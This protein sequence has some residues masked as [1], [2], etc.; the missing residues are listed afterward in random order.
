[1]TKTFCQRVVE[2]CEKHSDKTAMRIVGD[3]TEIYSYGEMLKQIRSVAY[4]ISQESVEFGDRVALIGENHPCW[5]IAYLG[6]LYRGAVCVPV[7]PHGEIETITNFLENSEA[8]LA[9]LSP[10][11]IEKFGQIQEKLGRHIP[12][13]VWRM[14][15]DAGTRTNGDEK[16]ISEKITLSSKSSEKQKTKN[17]KQYLNGFQRFEEWA[18][19][20][21]P[22]SFAKAE[23]PAKDEDTALLIYTSGTTGMPKGV[24]LTHG[25]ITAEDRKSVV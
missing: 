20:D 16:I 4:R 5:A 11:V 7:D 6:A 19:T 10:D 22:E 24:P 18:E 13:V 15:G 23:T 14:N 17:K 1:M 8:K 9:F 25:N 2:S 3:E 21:F 12:A